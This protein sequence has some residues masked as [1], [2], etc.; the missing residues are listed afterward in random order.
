MF[1]VEWSPPICGVRKKEVCP[2]PFGPVCWSDDRPGPVMIEIG[3]EIQHGGRS[4]RVVSNGLK[5][6]I[7][8]TMKSTLHMRTYQRKE[9][10]PTGGNT[11]KKR[12]LLPS[13]RGNRGTIVTKLALFF[14]F[15]KPSFWPAGKGKRFSYLFFVFCDSFVRC[16]RVVGSRLLVSP[17]PMLRCQVP[18]Q[19]RRQN[20]NNGTLYPFHP[21][22]VLGVLL[23]FF[24]FSHNSGVSIGPSHMHVL[25]SAL[26]SLSQPG[27]SD[28]L[29]MSRP[30]F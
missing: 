12:H 8:N 10:L 21:C 22:P 30:G 20:I 25:S 29:W 7:N 24:L 2:C 9:R 28:D 11:K 13:I 17:A 18:S 6:N 19:L 23:E 3:R 16:S 26:L 15:Q 5:G 4:W 1:E 14:N 27:S